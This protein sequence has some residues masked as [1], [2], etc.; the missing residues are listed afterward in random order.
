MTRTQLTRRTVLTA[1]GASTALFGLSRLHGSAGDL[2]SAVVEADTSG[3]AATALT[4]T[5]TDRQYWDLVS[6]FNQ[7]WVGSPD[8]VRLP[9]TTEQVVNAVR[10]AV[11]AG[12]RL[13]VRG[14][15]HG[16]EDWIY[17]SQ[18]KVVVDMSLMR[19]VYF[20]PARQAF[21]VEAGA[22]LLDVY[23]GLYEGYGVT[24]PAG[25]CATVGIGG[26][27]CGG[28]YGMLSRKH[29]LIV[30]Y[31]EAVEVV[32]VSATGIV[33]PVVATRDPADPNHDLWWAHTGGGGGTF[34]VVTRY[35]FR[36]K[37]T[38]STDPTELLPAP[39]VQVLSVT[40]EWPWDQITEQGFAKLLRAYGTWHE[41]H[42]GRA[43]PYAG[44]CSWLFVP[45]RTG[46]K[47]NVLI[48]MDGSRGDAEHLV[49]AFLD[50]LD[51]AAGVLR[52]ENVL[53]T[54]WL[55]ATRHMGMGSPLQ[56]SPTL[57]G[58]HKSAYLRRSFTEEHIAAAWKHLTRADYDNGYGMFV[59]TSYG[60][61]IN[62][63]APDATAVHQR[64]AILK[65]LFQTYWTD[66][67]Q[68]ARH[69]SWLRDLYEEMYAS[70]GGVPVPGEVTAGCYVNYPDGDISDPARN[71][72]GVPWTTLY[73]GDNYSRLQRVKAAYDP[74]DFF[75]H[76]QSVRLPGVAPVNGG[77]P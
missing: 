32:T 58:E 39:P 19:R 67:S 23:T 54:E 26:H 22:S 73:W 52:T 33:R 65:L 14:G 7:R 53:R 45:H 48:Q 72:S 76:A 59:A 36:S 50:E 42:S 56:T 63:V 21:A 8:A 77:R 28:G 46:G 74:T 66:P 4:V 15:G 64:D 10:E 41:R 29:G 12:K 57:R 24:V 47:I 35:W 20:D 70:T 17:N 49:R 62:D 2:L 51:A 40:A 34:G 13:S 68:D 44:L 25:V 5:P 69:V 37:N 27:A 3:A 11:R 31:L 6:P 61:A 16:Y 75:R 55:K 1:A 71:Q 18:I 9:T 30:D 38:T 43:D 60:G